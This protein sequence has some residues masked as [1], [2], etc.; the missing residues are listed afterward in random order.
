M[1]HVYFMPGMAASPKIFENI[2]LPEQEFK[3]HWLKWLPPKKN[4][5]LHEYCKRISKNIV[6]EKPILIGVSFG[7]IIVQ[8]IAEFFEVEKLIIISS[9]KTKYELPRRMRF[10]RKTKLYKILPTS[11]VNYFDALEKIAFSK[12]VKSRIKLYKKF[13]MVPDNYYMDWALDKVVN[14]QQEKPPKGIIHIHGENDVIFPIKYISNAVVVPNGTHIMIVNR[15]RWF[16]EN[17]PNILKSEKVE[18]QTI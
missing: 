4:E 8:E 11:L 18:L 14:W 17:L 2:K 12:V 7:G 1:V 6:H 13:L 15:F 9:V 5:S 3:I 10:A 16:N